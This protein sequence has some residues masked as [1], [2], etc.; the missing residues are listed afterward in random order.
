[1]DRNKEA[2]SKLRK[3]APPPANTWDVDDD[4]TKP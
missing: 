2:L 3:H 1:M 4:V